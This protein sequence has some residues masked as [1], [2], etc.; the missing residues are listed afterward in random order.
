MRHNWVAFGVLAIACSLLLSTEVEAVAAA[1]NGNTNG[2][3]S[4]STPRHDPS[5]STSVVQRVVWHNQRL[6]G[7]PEPPAP[8]RVERVFQKVQLKAPIY[9]A[10]EP[11]TDLLW[12]VL[13][14][15]EKERPSRI[16]R[17]RDQQDADHSDPVL[18]IKERL[19]YAVTFAPG[20]RSNGNVYVFSNGATGASERTNRISRFTVARQAPF[21]CDPDSEKVILSWRSA[22]HDGGDLAF[23]RDGMLYITAGDGTSDSDGWDSGQDLSNLLATLIRIDVDHPAAGQ[24]Y[25]VPPDNPFIHLP[26]A[27]PEI[28]AYGFRNPWR[29]DIDRKTGDIWVGNNGQDLWE[30]AYLVRR[31]DNFGWSVF[32]GSHPFH[33][34]RRRG[35]TPIVAPTIEHSHAEFRSLTGGVVYYGDVLSEL[36]GTYIYGDYS[37]GKIWG[38]RHRDGKL[39]WHRELVDTTLQIVGFRVSHRGELL[40]LDGGGGIYRLAPALPSK[41]PLKFPKRLSETGLFVSVRDHRP[42]PGL[43]PYSVNVPGWADG[44]TS[45]RLIALSGPATIGYASERGWNFPNETVLVQTLS[46]PMAKGRPGK[47]R[48]IETR[49]LLKQEGEWAGYSYRWNAAQTDATLV[50]KAGEAL[51]IEVQDSAGATARQ[52]WHIPSR[53]DCLACHSRAVNFVLGTTAPQM[54]RLQDYGPGTRQENQ[55]TALS[56]MGVLPG[57]AKEKPESVTK[58][59]DPYDSQ[60]ELEKRARSYL[61]A[62]CS[63][64]HVEAG[65]GNARMEFEFSRRRDG[66]NLIGS[67]PQHDTFGI[68]NAMLVA[69]GE[70][71]RSVLLYRLS[72]RG[73][74][75]MPPLMT[76]RVD[77][78]AVALFREWIASLK[79]EYTFVREWTLD[80]LLPD[81]GLP[82]AGAEAEPSISAGRDIF[83]KVGCV[84]C[85]R[86]GG[87]GGAVGPDLTGIAAR[88]KKRDILEAILDPSKSIADEFASYEIE[89]RGGE[90][91]TGRVEREDAREVVVRTGSAVDEL[92][93]I[94]RAKVLQRRKSAVSNMPVGMLNVLQREQILDLLAYLSSNEKNQ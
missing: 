85:H 49:L 41:G 82:G 34:L 47:P 62:N 87:S 22:G 68:T 81:H 84:Q 6:L 15:G 60:A 59:V 71:D 50:D 13:Q 5:Q 46:L 54:N 42:D 66:M 35:P 40:V 86:F 29:M 78:R 1:A 93:H 56:Q 65:G 17:L 48:R 74:G 69:P 67:R 4:G 38:A 31:G 25:G 79:P 23:G 20:Y 58:L 57:A 92:V 24:L 88:L 36:N 8:Y 45:E 27:R 11:G 37:T 21:A 12:V 55:L 91:V 73:R 19:I 64:C 28:W 94:P 43:I 44:A 3:T 77:D 52:T 83:R 18:E 90:S 76:C 9:V 75:Q 61:H 10:D 63:V 72:H 33:P 70:P 53:A 89:V 7:S 80:A 32:E 39:I 16:L 30:T 2:G 14:G 51:T 26:G